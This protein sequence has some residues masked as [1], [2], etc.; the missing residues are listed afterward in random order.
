MEIFDMIGIDVGYVLI[1]T[2]AGTVVI[3]LIL[4]ILVIV[5][6]SK[7]KK[8]VQKYEN[9]MQG[10]EG[11]SLEELVT[12]RFSEIDELKENFT[13]ANSRLG[14]IDDTLVHTYQKMS[15]VKYNAFHQMGGNLS[16][17]LVLLTANNDGCIINSMHNNR[18]GC[19]VY[20]KN[21]VKGECDVLLSEEE[22][23]ALD[24]AKRKHI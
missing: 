22:Q 20:I 16:F 10:A 13:E 1:G 19:Y 14:K 8:L 23:Q 21:V 11:N 9:F 6:F 3:A 15:I 5:L 2:L 24:E 17:V 4:F 12:K 18:E 7:Q